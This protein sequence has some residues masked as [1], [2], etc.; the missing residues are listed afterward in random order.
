MDNIELQKAIAEFNQQKFYDCHDTLEAIWMESVEPDKTF[1]QGI[2]QVAV[3]C[4]HLTN[5]NWKGAVIL[6]GEGIRK[7]REY[8][9]EYL[10]INVNKLVEESYDLLLALQQIDPDSVSIFCQKLLSQELE[11]NLSFPIIKTTTYT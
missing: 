3:G 7:L 6:L 4:Y 2:L 5:I 10:D 9:P 8:E 1:Y 11:N